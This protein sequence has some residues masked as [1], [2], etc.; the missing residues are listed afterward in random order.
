MNEILLMKRKFLI[1]VFGRESKMRK[2]LHDIILEK[3]KR[4][5]PSFWPNSRFEGPSKWIFVPTDP[6]K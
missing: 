3:G 1:E 6:L 2:S 4:R 5:V